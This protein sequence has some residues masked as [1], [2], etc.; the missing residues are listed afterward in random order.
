MSILSLLGWHLSCVLFAEIR[1]GMR[2]SWHW[3]CSPWA[4]RKKALW[5]LDKAL[6][7][8]LW[9]IPE[10][11][12]LFP[13]SLG[14][15]STSSSLFQDRMR[16]RELAGATGVR[17]DEGYWLDAFF[18]SVPREGPGKFK[19]WVAGIWECFY[20]GWKF[21]G[22]GISYQGTFSNS[23]DQVYRLVASSLSLNVFYSVG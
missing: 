12:C 21:V 10:W 20:L 14:T 6:Q 16:V 8:Y 7:R 15:R 3:I 4:K 22:M 5:V 23:C 11:W 19:S 18:C 2:F 1:R 17:V 9:E 13:F